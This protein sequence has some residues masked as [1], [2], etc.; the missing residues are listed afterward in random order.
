MTLDLERPL[1]VSWDGAEVAW[2]E[3]ANV[4][5]VFMCDRSKRKH[6]LTIG[7]ECSA[8][9]AAGRALSAAGVVDGLAVLVA[10]RCLSC[11]HDQVYDRDADVLWDLGP[12]DYGLLGSVAPGA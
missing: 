5:P 8:C 10:T 7:P 2:R 6:G 12:E 11:G 3:W 1:P 4:G 9:G